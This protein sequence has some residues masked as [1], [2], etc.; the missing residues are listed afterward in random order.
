[1]IS[2]RSFFE[3][4]DK[5]ILRNV[6]AKAFNKKGLVNNTTILKELLERYDNPEFI[7][8]MYQEFSPWQ[9][10]ILFLIAMSG[11]RGLRFRELR[12]VVPINDVQKLASFLETITKNYFVWKS[13]GNQENAVYRAFSG[14]LL[15][16]SDFKEESIDSS[17][18]LVAY[19]YLLDFH[20][21]EF[22]SLLKTK[23]MHINAAGDLHRRTL[24][25]CSEF[26]QFSNSLFPKA[27]KDEILLIL[28]FL[29][30]NGWILVDND[31][32][33]MLAEKANQ[34]L[35]NNGFRL[36]QEFFHWWKRVRF[37]GEQAHLAFLLNRLKNKISIEKALDLFWPLDPSIRLSSKTTGWTFE[38]LPLPL[39][40][41]WFFGI[42]DFYIDKTKHIAALQLNKEGKERAEKFLNKKITE[43]TALPNFEMIIPAFASPRLLYYAV[44]F[45]TVQNDET[46]L[47]FKFEKEHF[48]EALRLGFSEAEVRQFFDWIKL[49]TNVYET[50]EEW[51][52]SFFGADI[53]TARLLKIED[54]AILEDLSG[55]P[56]FMSYVTEKIP[57][58]GFL[59]R[60]EYEKD[61]R[62]MLVHYGLTPAEEQS[63]L[64]TKTFESAT[65]TKAFMLDFPKEQDPD[66]LLS[67]ESSVDSIIQKAKEKFG[68]KF[69]ALDMSSLVQ[70]LRYAKITG[71]LFSVKI[72]NPERPTAKAI[73][74]TYSISALKLSQ[75]PF[76]GQVTE[77][78]KTKSEKLDLSFI[79]EIR[80]HHQ[81][82]IS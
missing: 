61:I 34:F 17:L 78:K 40:E 9:Q 15:L 68:E 2:L 10:R 63:F 5:T 77:Y 70:A 59:I 72:A 52:V 26:F 8:T 38:N 42:I 67:E 80:L 3:S 76:T 74:K 48:I 41:L 25:A 39:R 54:K 24:Q 53:F 58:Y 69:Q 35:E 23:K 27:F 11:N 4:M 57:G 51:A 29:T 21:C 73:E 20:L 19:D 28:Q 22:L 55:F 6:Y 1:M 65:W 36:H 33:L 7:K 75:I 56:Q 32:Y 14:T 50:L 62:N 47:R 79:K 66:Y 45:A 44:S 49:P 12:L 60:E 46:F 18:K 37:N 30:S 43:I 82:E 71:T 13:V 64:E 31:S 81:K 16:F